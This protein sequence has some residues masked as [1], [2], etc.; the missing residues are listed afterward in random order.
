[1]EHT[2]SFFKGADGTEL[3]TQIW[4]PDGGMKTAVLILHG[5]GDHSNRYT[6]VGEAFAAAGI[7]TMAVDFRG[8]GQT[9]GPRGYM[10]S[11]DNEMFMDIDLLL[12]EMKIQFPNVPHVLYGHS[13]G[14][15]IVLGY[16]IKKRPTVAGIIASSPWLELAV[17]PPS[18]LISA[19]RLIRSIY[20]KFTRDMGYTDGLL[21]RDPQLDV[22]S[23][24]D[25]LMH[26]K[27]TAGLFVEAVDNGRFVL[28]NASQIT[29]PLLLMHGTADPVTSHAASQQVASTAP[30]A[31]LKLWPNALHEL[32][33]EINRYEVIQ[34]MI[35]WLEQFG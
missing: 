19:M 25:S 17:Q 23:R 18:I 13:T 9:A 33:N 28:K 8:H 15:G 3:Y 30:N 22:V 1:M 26:S 29:V 11:Y 7:G 34:Y 27:M 20:P 10:K 32:H 35:D 4:R 31:T 12:A 5:W 14:G 21:S 2:S 16:A 24:N 6:H